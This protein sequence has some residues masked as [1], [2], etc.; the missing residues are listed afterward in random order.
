[1][2]CDWQIF[3]H[4]HRQVPELAKGEYLNSSGEIVSIPGSALA[5]VFR[6]M[7]KAFSL[8]AETIGAIKPGEIMAKGYNDEWPEILE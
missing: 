8:F 6:G 2:L 5:E 1:M 4:E 3:W 7:A